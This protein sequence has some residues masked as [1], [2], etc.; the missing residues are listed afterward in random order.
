MYEV[1]SIQIDPNLAEVAV[2]MTSE[3]SEQRLHMKQYQ[4]YRET[5]KAR[6]ALK[7]IKEDYFINHDSDS[8]IQATRY[9]IC[10]LSFAPTKTSNVLILIQNLAII[11]CKF[12]DLALEAELLASLQHPNIIKLRGIAYSGPEGL[13]NGPRYVRPLGLCWPQ[14]P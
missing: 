2:N 1:K 11:M 7:H 9:V 6:Y 5:N 13:L 12:S 14:Y 8:F 4:N 3:E 10:C